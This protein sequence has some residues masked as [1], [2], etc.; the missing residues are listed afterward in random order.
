MSTG[1]EL[2]HR[3]CRPSILRVH[4]LRVTSCRNPA[5]ASIRGLLALSRGTWT[6]P[7]ITLGG[8]TGA[9]GGPAPSSHQGPYSEVSGGGLAHQGHTPWTSGSRPERCVRRA[10]SSANVPS[11]RVRRLWAMGRDA[12]HDGPPWKTGHHGPVESAAGVASGE[13]PAGRD[14]DVP[15][16]SSLISP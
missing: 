11:R 3:H 14:Q 8:A 13:A 9:G 4:S 15:S 7:I 16:S 1:P 12:G 5:Y 6:L 10:L 2:R